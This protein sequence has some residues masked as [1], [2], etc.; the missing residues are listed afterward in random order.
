MMPQYHIGSLEEKSRK[1]LIDGESDVPPN[2]DVEKQPTFLRPRLWKKA[3]LTQKSTISW[4]TRIFTYKLEHEEQTLG[5]PVGQHLMVRLRDGSTGD[6]IIRSY[7]PVSETNK[8]GYLDL[9]V[10]IYFDTKEGRGGKMTQAMDALPIGEAIDLKGPIGKF[11]YLGG[12]RCAINGAVR[13]VQKLCLVCGGSGITPI[14]QVLRAIMQDP[15]DPTQ[16]V[17]FSGNRL[18]EDILCKDEL[19]A[20]AVAN[21]DKCKLLYTLTKAPE[22]WNGLRGRLTGELIRQHVVNDG[23]TMALICGP[24]PMEVSI[25]AALLQ[26]GWKDEDIIRF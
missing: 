7:T 6:A 18:L 26:D 12:G 25:Q 16:C 3:V 8:K 20:F 1:I 15:T 24:E 21:K 2:G 11:E 13:Q 23:Q 17:V 10:K 22:H 9:L 19:D 14:F 4:D 5:L